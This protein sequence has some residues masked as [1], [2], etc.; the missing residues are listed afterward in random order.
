M[1]LERKILKEKVVEDEKNS[2]IGSLYDDE[3]T[4]HQHINQLRIK[5]REM[6][7]K[8]DRQMDQ[9]NEENLEIIGKQFELDA[10]LEI[11]NKQ[12]AQ[13]N[14]KI[15]EYSATMHKKQYDLKND[16]S[17]VNN[18]RQELESEVTQQI[19]DLDKEGKNHYDNKMYLYKDEHFGKIN[20]ERHEQEIKLLNQIKEENEKQKAE[21]EKERLALQ[22]KFN[23]NAELQK[24]IAEARDKSAEIERVIVEIQAMELKAEGLK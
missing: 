20:N 16:Y 4:S 9:L 24:S 23:S 3:K 5:Y 12:N 21:H 7:R 1:D 22:Q 6:K 18:K 11:I 17:T 19:K 2:G 15:K 13:L 14:D 10:Q 8:F